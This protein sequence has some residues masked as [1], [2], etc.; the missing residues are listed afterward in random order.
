MVTEFP[1]ILLENC[2]SGGGRYDPG[3]LYYSPQIWCSDNTDAIERLRIQEGTAMVYPL[4]TMGAHVSDCPCHSNGRV[5]PFDT[6][7]YIAFAGT[8]GYELDITKIVEEE[9]NRI[10]EQIRMYHK[11]ND[12]IREGDYYR[13]T[14]YQENHENDSFMVVS[15]DK[16]EAV[17]V[18]IQVE[19]R[20]KLR[21]VRIRLKGLEENLQYMV[22][23]DDNVLSGAILM[24]AGII[25]DGLWG[26]YQGRLI[27]LKKVQ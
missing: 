5:T 14:S 25:M 16:S 19:A 15:K 11:Y 1:D 27:Y 17:A 24:N 13:L 6:R 23:S 18:Y 12:L 9:R 10:P 2:S 8:F 4:G 22:S 7:A 21:S 26:D 3:M 20:P